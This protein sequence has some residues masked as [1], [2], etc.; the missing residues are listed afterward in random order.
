MPP[1]VTTHTATASGISLVRV[2][3]ERTGLRRPKGSYITLDM[4]AFARIDE[5]NEAYVWAIASQMR[6]LLPKEGLVLVAGVG[7][8]A[9]TADALGPETSDCDKF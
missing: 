8:R 4:P 1:G 6:A 7:N 2:D 3:V 9:V 5:R